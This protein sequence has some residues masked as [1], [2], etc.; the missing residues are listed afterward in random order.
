MTRYVVVC[1]DYRSDPYKDRAGAERHLAGIEKMG[2]CHLE[3]RVEEV[4]P[5]ESQAT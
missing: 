1:A 2:A 3:H 5:A 4:D